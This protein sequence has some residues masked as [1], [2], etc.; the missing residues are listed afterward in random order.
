VLRSFSHRNAIASI[1]N[2]PG[3]PYA[4]DISMLQNPIIAKMLD[5]WRNGTPKRFADR[6]G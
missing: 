4:N 1:T 3:F 6:Y 2:R 5:P